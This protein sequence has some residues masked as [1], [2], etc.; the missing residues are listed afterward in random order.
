MIFGWY[1]V[2]AAS[3][4]TAGELSENFNIPNKSLD[5]V[6]LGSHFAFGY[7][8]EKVSQ[9]EKE[10]GVFTLNDRSGAGVFQ[11]RLF[12]PDE[13]VE[14]QWENSSA[15]IVILKHLLENGQIEKI[16]K[17]RGSFAGAFFNHKT[18]QFFL[19]R[20]HLGIEPLYY[21]QKGNRISF[22]SSL[23]LLANA[24]FYKKR[25]NYQALYR[26]LL[27]NYNPGHDTFFAEIQKLGSGQILSS[28]DGN[29][30]IT[31]FWSISYKEIDGRPIEEIKKELLEKLERAV[32]IRLPQNKTDIG[33]FLSGG[34]DSSSVVGISAPRLEYPLH[35]FS[36]RCKGKSFD[37]SYY[38]EFMSRYYHTQHHLVEYPPEKVAEVEELVSYMEEPFS[39]I[40]IEIAS[41]LLGKEAKNRV[42]I[43]L[44]G[45][46]GD[47]LFAGHPVYLAEKMSRRYDMLPQFAKRAIYRLS[48]ILPDT[49]E[50]NSF[51]V[52]VKRFSYSAQFSKSLYSNRWRIYYTQSQIQSLV[53]P[54]LW[55]QMQQTDPLEYFYQLY[56]KSDA[57][58]YLSKSLYADYYT[59][60][61]FYLR[62]MAVL[63][64]FGIESR[65]PL[66]DP[67]MVTFSAKIPAEYKIPKSMETK[68]I[69][70]VTMEGVLPDEIVHRKDKL[71]HSVPMKNWMRGNEF[72][73][74]FLFGH[75]SKET[76]EK[77]GFFDPR[78]VGNL[79]DEHLSRKENHSHRL[80]SLMVLEMWLQ[81]NFG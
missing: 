72:V 9:L 32:S 57:E 22:S 47:E 40:G 41:F 75:L 59:V 5:R 76:I 25:L 44:T 66:L 39:D 36:F 54:E 55:D 68:Y 63:R 38:A 58:D 43:I 56:R 50:K 79:I 29:F 61:D 20:D 18:N 27:F 6:V 8:P 77:R 1:D 45:D 70:H 16:D 46:G 73:K 80:W 12:E 31:S 19:F 42:Q 35:T 37:E 62:R 7:A 26:Y 51:S 17:L 49:E 34:M 78:F 30:D 14:G 52:K 65:F 15:S 23:K 10:S 64:N 3:N 21:F 69:Q 81:K 11:G 71:G 13:R 28:K 2:T 53:T 48:R 74:N 60:V 33:V 24:K 4:P 67:D